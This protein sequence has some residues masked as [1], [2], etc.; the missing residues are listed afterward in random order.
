MEKII[1]KEENYQGYKIYFYEDK[2]DDICKKYC[3]KE[4]EM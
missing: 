3:T 2:F 1:L 4:G